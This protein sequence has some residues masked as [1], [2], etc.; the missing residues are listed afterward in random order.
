MKKL[1]WFVIM[2]FCVLCSLSFSQRSKLKCINRSKPLFLLPFPVGSGYYV[3]QGNCGT[4]SHFGN[5]QYAYDFRMPV[6]SVITAMR[7]GKVVNLREQFQDGSNT[8]DSL[9]F[10]IILHEDSTAS[11]YLHLTY[12]GVA[13]KKG[14]FVKAGDTIAYSGNTGMS[15]EPHLHVDVTGYCT[16]APCQTLPFSFRNC[17]DRVPLQGRT[18]VALKK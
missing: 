10:L 3:M 2:F 9:N 8:N 12:N 11:R 13:V 18:Y 16:K 5:Q 6:G 1:Q 14:D 4:Y 17:K 7:S 15:T